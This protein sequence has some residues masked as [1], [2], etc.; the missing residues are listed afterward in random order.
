MKVSSS[1]K[2]R[3]MGPLQILQSRS[4]VFL[5]KCDKVTDGRTVEQPASQPGKEQGWSV[6]W[7]H[8]KTPLFIFQVDQ[9]DLED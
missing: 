1:K 9:T 6:G 4:P 3:G 7:S 8:I 2:N 5:P